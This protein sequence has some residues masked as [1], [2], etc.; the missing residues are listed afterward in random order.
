MAQPSPTFQRVRELFDYDSDKGALRWRPR[1][2]S[3]FAD[4]R[5][6]ATWN[7]RFAGKEAGSKNGGGYIHVDFDGAKHKVHRLVWLRE[8][9]TWPEGDIDHQNGDRADNRWANLRAVTRKENTRSQALYRNN[10]SGV[11]GVWWD[12]TRRKWQANI[13]LNGKVVRLGW[14]EDKGA[15]VAARMVAEAS[16]GFHQNHGR[17]A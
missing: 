8:T 4:K 17:A 10:T 13:G 14:Y 9:G 7:S 1:P 12:R 15:A 16:H 3:D 2:V 6:W 11:A 5:A